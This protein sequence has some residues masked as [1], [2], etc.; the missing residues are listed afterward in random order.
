MGFYEFTGLPFYIGIGVLILSVL[1]FFYRRAVQD[2]AK[3]TFRDSDVRL[4]PTDEQM[5]LL[6][7]EV[8]S[9]TAEK[10][11][12]K[13]GGQ[14]PPFLPGAAEAAARRLPSRLLRRSVRR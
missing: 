2:K 14:P 8:R 10:L 9:L 7:E 12:R 11:Q 6:R 1:L 5:A 13:G 4:T 3:I